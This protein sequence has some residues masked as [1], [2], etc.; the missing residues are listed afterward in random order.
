MTKAAALSLAADNIRV[1]SVH[2]GVIQT[3]M[4]NNPEVKEAVNKFIKTIPLQRVATPQDISNM[5]TFLAS[6]ESSYSTGSK[7]IVD[8]GLLAKL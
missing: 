6:D 4:L 7:F 3:P 2:P 5:V 1:H 8:D